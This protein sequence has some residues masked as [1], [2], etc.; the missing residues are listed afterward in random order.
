MDYYKILNVSYDASLKEIE[1]AYNDL[2]SFYNPVH[3]YSKVAYEKYREIN[4]AYEVLKDIK[5]REM[6]NLSLHDISKKEESTTMNLDEESQEKAKEKLGSKG[7]VES[8]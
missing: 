8:I 2:S 7:R 6:Y 5:Q 4:K 1:T 3:N